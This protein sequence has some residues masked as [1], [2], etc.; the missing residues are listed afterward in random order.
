[1]ARYLITQ[2][3]LSSIAPLTSVS[4][5]DMT[6]F[7]GDLEK[8]VAPS[9]S[10]EDELAKFVNR[11]EFVPVEDKRRLIDAM[12][13]LH[14]LRIAPIGEEELIREVLTAWDATEQGKDKE[15]TT[16]LEANIRSVL[17]AKVLQASTKGLSLMSDQD[18]LFLSSRILTDVRPVFADDLSSP[19][20]GSV[21]THTL[22]ISMRSD[23]RPQSFFVVLDSEDLLQLRDSVERAIAKD[24]LLAEQI[25]AN[26]GSFAPSLMLTKDG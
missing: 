23:G 25:R 14:Y 1:M 19:L 8:A 20:L 10:I 12:L 26:G 17:G 22:K 7:L 9:L 16:A 21:V 18:R 4:S 2:E 24:K 5:A 11:A 3:L 13:R 15:K 6:R